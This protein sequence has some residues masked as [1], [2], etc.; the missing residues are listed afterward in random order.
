MCI[1]SAL[2]VAPHLARSVRVRGASVH[3]RSPRTTPHRSRHMTQHFDRHGQAVPTDPGTTRS[4]SGGSS[5]RYRRITT[6]AATG[7]LAVSAVAGLQAPAS[8]ALSSV[9][10]IDPATL[11]PSSYSD[12]N[13]LAL[14][15]CLSGDANCLAGPDFV[16]IHKKGGDAEAFYYAA[17]ATVGPITV[18]NALE[19]AYAADGPGQEVTFMRTQ[20]ADQTAGL[21]PN[22]QYTI[23]DPYGVLTCTAD[24]K[25]QIRNNAC[26]TETTPVPEDFTIALRGRINPFLAWDTYVDR[27]LVGALPP[28]GYIGDNVTPHKV[29]GSPTGF[30]KVRVEGPGFDGTCTNADGSTVSGCEETDLF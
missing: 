14:A 18:H 28:A 5:R 15:L 17:D 26:R 9:G 6:A 16:D 21:V 13:G 3:G 19:A 4:S 30:N 11:F 2:P 1:S 25:G 8:A 23:T 22:A 29:L 20:V 24:A 12:T 10:A 27:T 7:L